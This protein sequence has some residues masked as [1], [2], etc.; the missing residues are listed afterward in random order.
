MQPELKYL[1]VDGLFPN[2]F[3]PRQSIT[4]K[5]LL[6]L[7]DSIR[8][9]RVLQP[10]VVTETPA[11]YQIILGERRWRAA[12]LAGLQE[13]PAIILSEIDPEQILLLVLSE[14]LQMQPLSIF[15][16]GLIF[17]Y[18]VKEK[19]MSIS[20]ISQAVSVESVL[21]EESLAALNLPD[22]IKRAYQQGLLA[23]L[24]IKT[25]LAYQDPL[26]RDEKAEELIHAHQLPKE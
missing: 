4:R 22:R 7:T 25:I 21:I 18:L 19:K 23:D 2:P 24:D 6:S 13:I 26:E 3:K 17:A 8:K 1:S 16:R 10:V 20:E 14:N 15:E 9:F 11:G 5:D 12:K